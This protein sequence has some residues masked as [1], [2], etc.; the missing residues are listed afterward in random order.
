MARPLGFFFFSCLGTLGVWPRTLPARAREPCTLP[1][2]QHGRGG[3]GGM[4]GGRRRGA[5][6]TQRD[7]I[8]LRQRAEAG[9]WPASMAASGGEGVAGLTHGC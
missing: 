3:T 6:T 4:S 7:K 8:E 5:H 9:A 2:T 1:A